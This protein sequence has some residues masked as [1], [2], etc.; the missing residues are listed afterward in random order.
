MAAAERSVWNR[1]ARVWAKRSTLALLV[2]RDLKVRYANSVLGYLWTI[3]DPLLMG[4]TYWFVFGVLF[5]RGVGHEPYVVFLLAALLPWQWFTNAVNEGSQAFKRDGALIRSTSLPREIWV[6]RVVLSKCVEFLLSLPVLA[7]FVLVY[8]VFLHP[9]QM[10][11][12]ANLVLFPVAIVL[13]FLLLLALGLLLAPLVVLLQDLEPL[14][15]VWLRWMM[16]ASPVIYSMEMVYNSR[17]PTWIHDLF[18]I[19]PLTGI[20]SLYRAG[21]FQESLHPTAIWVAVAETFLLLGLGLWVFAR[22]EPTVLK[23]L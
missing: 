12:N 20:L 9:G 2:R 5:P 15:R 6:C 8:L 13:Q 1:P 14:I 7:G 11:L 19:N 23:E 17:L 10:D 22:F 4:L 16:Y 21:F 18:L 3:L